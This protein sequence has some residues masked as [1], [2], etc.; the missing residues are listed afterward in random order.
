V[1]AWTNV[2][3]PVRSKD[4]AAQSELISRKLGCR[5]VSSELGSGFVTNVQ[6]NGKHLIYPINNNRSQLHRHAPAYPR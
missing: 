2:S 5:L 4:I 1:R 3:W 6:A